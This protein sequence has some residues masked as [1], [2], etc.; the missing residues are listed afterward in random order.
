MPSGKLQW[1]REPRGKLES[2]HCLP[3][4]DKEV[5]R[6]LRDSGSGCKVNPVRRHHN[7]TDPELP[8]IN[9]CHISVYFLGKSRFFQWPARF[10]VFRLPVVGP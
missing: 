4:W 8:P 3:P 1:L 10:S 6:L 9:S 5:G 7:S 2:Q